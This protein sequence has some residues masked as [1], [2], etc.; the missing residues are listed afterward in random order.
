LGAEVSGLS[1]GEVLDP[2]DG[3]A[4]VDVDPGIEPGGGPLGLPFGDFGLGDFGP[5]GLCP[6]W[7]PAPLGGSGEGEE[8]S[9]APFPNPPPAELGRSSPCPF[10]GELGGGRSPVVGF[11]GGDGSTPVSGGVGCP[12]LE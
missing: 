5:F 6:A 8:P 4:P 9:P 7:P 12:G 10:S 1:V 3:I 2:L 11:S